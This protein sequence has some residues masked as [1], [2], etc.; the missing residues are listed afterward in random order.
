MHSESIQGE[1]MHFLFY[2]ALSVALVFTFAD[3]RSSVYI[4]P[5]NV[6][7]V[8]HM[9]YVFWIPTNDPLCKYLSLFIVA[10]GGIHFLAVI[11]CGFNSTIM[12]ATYKGLVI[13]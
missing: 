3:A 13:F 4:I 2:T 1:L 10:L 12:I 8:H 9:P 7:F 5:N 11:T 6:T